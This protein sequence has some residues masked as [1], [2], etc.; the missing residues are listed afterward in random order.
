MPT[1][2]LLTGILLAVVVGTI[3]VLRQREARRDL[4]ADEPSASSGDDDGSTALSQASAIFN[5]VD[6]DE[7]SAIDPQILFPVSRDQPYTDQL[8]AVAC[9]LKHRYGD[10]PIRLFRVADDDHDL[11]ACDAELS[12]IRDRIADHGETANTAIR[13]TTGEGDVAE[14]IVRAASSADD[15]LLLMDWDEPSSGAAYGR[16]IDRVLARTPLPVYLFRFSGELPQTARL[17]LVIP[18]Q[19]DHHEGFYEA[20]YNAKQLASHL[21]VPITVYVFEQNVQHYRTLFDL[22]EVDIPAEFRS[23]DSWDALGSTLERESGPDDLLVA[24]GVRE[25]EIGWHPEQQTLSERFGA[26]PPRSFALLFLRED[27]PAYDDRFLRTE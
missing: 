24:L 23:I 26:L 7:A 22:V 11:S 9:A 2:L 20:I 15:D 19:V 27:T 18:R 3:V 10:S 13:T 8:T 16:I 4:G 6:V 12:T 17:R 25:D 21:D 5:R 1:T 14:E